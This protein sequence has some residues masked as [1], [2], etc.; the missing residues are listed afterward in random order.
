MPLAFGLD[1]R[2][3]ARYRARGRPSLK[4]CWGGGDG[5]GRGLPNLINH[6]CH[7]YD[8]ALALAGDPEVEWVSGQVDQLSDEPPDS[9]RRL[10]PAGTAQ[11]QL[12]NGVALYVTPS[13]RPGPA[14]EVLGTGGAWCC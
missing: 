4:G 6:G 1:R 10:D 3:S 11:V 7:W 14:F 9:R 12:A 13:G 2:W 5:G 8:V